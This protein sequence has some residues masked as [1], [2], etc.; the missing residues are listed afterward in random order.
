MLSILSQFI[1]L[2]TELITRLS[3]TCSLVLV[4]T[5]ALPALCAVL[6]GSN[7]NRAS[8]VLVK[9]ALQILLNLTRVSLCIPQYY[10]CTCCDIVCVLSVCGVEGQRQ[11]F[12]HATDN[13]WGII[14]KIS[15]FVLQA[16]ITTSLCLHVCFHYCTQIKRITYCI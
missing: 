8:L 14:I 3:D 5:G 7:R 4:E 15:I 6:D 10:H 9:I 11:V 12:P 2:L 13:P 1:S 16:A